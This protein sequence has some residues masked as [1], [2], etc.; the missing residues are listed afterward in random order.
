MIKF[1]RHIRQS[2]LNQGKTTKYF[3]Y[4]IGEILLV[5]I[6]IL[7]AVKINTWN[8]NNINDT[9]EQV[10]L[11]SL[12]SDLKTQITSME[13]VKK[14]YDSLIINAGEILV[15]FQKLKSVEKIPNLNSR[16]SALMW[17]TSFTEFKTSFTELI[18]TG[19]ISLIKNENLR[20]HII[21]FYQ[22]SESS[23]NS[24]ANNIEKVF[25]NIA[26]P[27]ITD[28]AIINPS[29]FKIKVEGITQYNFS[30]GLEAEQNRQ[31]KN[32]AIQ[33]KLINAINLKILATTSNKNSLKNMIGF[34]KILLE[35]LQKELHKK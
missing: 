32:P 6:G 33:K 15:D 3:K 14:F 9:K 11:A 27:I 29:D 24:A 13:S 16:I 1:F 12:E 25:Y 5:V 4:A 18:S 2:L 19:N 28:I 31:L 30:D 21:K 22:F 8:Q 23:N 20:T 10:Y 26:F 35:E 7:I 17:D 34:G